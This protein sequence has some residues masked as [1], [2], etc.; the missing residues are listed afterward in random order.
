MLRYGLASPSSVSVSTAT[1]FAE[2]PL[3]SHIF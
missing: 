3:V 2:P 1:R